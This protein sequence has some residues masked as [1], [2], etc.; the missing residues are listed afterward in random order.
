MKASEKGPATSLECPILGFQYNYDSLRL[1]RRGVT[2]IFI[3]LQI[4]LLEVFKSFAKNSF[5]I[6]CKPRLRYT[7]LTKYYLLIIYKLI[8]GWFF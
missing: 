2:I 6:A 5:R 7:S 1:E 4:I 3:I 8:F